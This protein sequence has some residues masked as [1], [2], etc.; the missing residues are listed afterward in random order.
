MRPQRRISGHPILADLGP[1]TVEFTFDGE[2]LLARPGEMIASALFAG[3]ISVFGHHHRDGGPQGIFCANGQCSQCTVLADG[4]PVK[5]C[6]VAVEPGMRVER[7]EGRPP[8]P[9]AASSRSR[10]TASSARWR[11]AGPAPAASTSAGCW[12]SA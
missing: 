10:P 2:P 4:R 7:A 3:G 9:A 11:T 8:L 5:S 12:P 1:A 6:M